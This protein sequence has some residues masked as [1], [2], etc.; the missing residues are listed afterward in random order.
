VP[1]TTAAARRD[2]EALVYNA[3]LEHCPT[4]QVV[5]IVSGKWSM[6]L[7]CAMAE[8]ASR[9]GELRRQV[10]GISQKMLTQ[11]LREL[12]RDGIVTRTVT[13]SV[14]VRVDY[15]LTALGRSLLVVTSAL[16]HWSE[17]HIEQILSSREEFDRAGPTSTMVEV[18]A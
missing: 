13:A 10:A 3:F 11:T 6:L 1:T 5:A 8:G 12:E 9:H 17:A 14:P 7:V 15:E 4:R 16:K 2:E 18:N